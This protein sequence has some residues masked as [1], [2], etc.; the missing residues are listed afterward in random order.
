MR[1]N[2]LIPGAG[3]FLDR[4]HQRQIKFLILTNNPQYTPVDLLYRLQRIGLN[5]H[6]ITF[7]PQ[8]W[9]PPV[10]QMADAHFPRNL[11]WAKAD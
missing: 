6:P 10:S 4:L 2:E 9:Q 8:P 5:L 3:E 7:T 11:W 1:G